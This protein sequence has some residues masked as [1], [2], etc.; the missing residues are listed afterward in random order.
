MNVRMVLKFERI[1][2]TLNPTPKRVCSPCKLVSTKIN[3]REGRKERKYLKSSQSQS[4]FS[5]RRIQTGQFHPLLFFNSRIFRIIQDRS[6]FDIEDIGSKESMS[7][8][9]EYQH[10]FES[11]SE[12][13]YQSPNPHC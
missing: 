4:Q 5:T 10:L 2:S 6:Q 12:I 11:L 3:R 9:L 7:Q 8:I 13:Y 1:L